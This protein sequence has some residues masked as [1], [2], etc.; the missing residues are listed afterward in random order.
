MS[1]F[2]NKILYAK[3]GETQ[4]FFLGQ[5]G[6]AIK[7]RN[8]QLLGIDLYLSECVER[9][10]GHMGF[11]RLLPKLLNP[12]ELEFDGIIATHPHFD[13]FDMDAIPELMSNGKSRLYASVE[14]EKEIERLRMT[15]DRI[16]YVRPGDIHVLGDYTLEFVSCDHGIAAMD[17]V[18]VVITVD[19][20]KVYIAGD[21]CLR[22]D[23]V[24]EYAEKGPFDIMLAPI[25]GAFGNMNEEE[26]VE[27]SRALEPKLTIPYHYGM[28]ASH[29]GNPGL[30]IEKMKERCPDNKFYIMAYGEGIIV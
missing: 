19:G 12:F 14:C 30:F 21:T 22:L 24:E 15:N 10:E 8:G 1:D 28:F 25:N 3:Y 7:S 17:A 26:C 20:K 29:G 23:R 5:A 6:F 11:K 27:L 9:V 2:A 16:T 18:G 4:L 13:H